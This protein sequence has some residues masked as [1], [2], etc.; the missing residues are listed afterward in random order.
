MQRHRVSITVDG[1]ARF[2]LEFN[3]GHSVRIPTHL[4]DELA[5]K[6]TVVEL[7]IEDVPVPDSEIAVKA[8]AV[9]RIIREAAQILESLP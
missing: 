1:R 6:P 3:P 9:R 2:E 4:A 7:L 5:R 8:R